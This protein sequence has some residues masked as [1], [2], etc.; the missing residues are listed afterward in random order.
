LAIPVQAADSIYINAYTDR[1]LNTGTVNV[2]TSN[3]TVY[4]NKGAWAKYIVDFSTMEAT[5]NRVELQYIKTAAVNG[6]NIV[7]I[8][9]DLGTNVPDNGRQIALIPTGN[10][11]NATSVKNSVEFNEISKNYLIGTKEV[12]VVFKG[13]AD[14]AQLQ[15]IR[16]YNSTETQNGNMRDVIIP[17]LSYTDMTP[18][19]PITDIEVNNSRASVFFKKSGWVKYGEVNFDLSPYPV[20]TLDIISGFSGTAQKP[21]LLFYIDGLPGENGAVKIGEFTPKVDSKE[22]APLTLETVN[23]TSSISGIHNLYVINGG[24]GLS[25]SYSM[26]R[27]YKK[28]SNE[29]TAILGAT[30]SVVTP[31]DI[32]A[33]DRYTSYYDYPGKPYDAN[34]IRATEIWPTSNSSSIKLHGNFDFGDGTIKYNKIAIDA[35]V[36]ENVANYTGKIEVWVDGLDT[37]IKLGEVLIDRVTDGNKIYQTFDT[38]VIGNVPYYTGAD[39][40]KKH[41]VFLRF[42]YAY[43]ANV[44]S[45]K[46][47]SESNNPTVI[48]SI[49]ED[50]SILNSTAN[51]PNTTDGFVIS[52]PNGCLND[53]SDSIYLKDDKNNNLLINVSDIDGKVHIKLNE[54]LH[55]NSKYTL[56][57][58]DSIINKLMKKTTLNDFDIELTQASIAITSSEIKANSGGSKINFSAQI[59]GQEQNLTAIVSVLDSNNKLMLCKVKS[60]LEW[61][62]IEF[63]L[64]IDGLIL[65]KNDKIKVLLIGSSYIPIADYVEYIVN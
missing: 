6:S 45:I 64:N 59:E 4:G 11:V 54:Y 14:F 29:K 38:D 53:L 12:F 40:D 42:S 31:N 34:Y 26:L 27:F 52:F 47:Y 49:L 1:V 5:P 39:N 2:N 28:T 8:V 62:N 57:M 33:C 41:K 58:P 15:A 65:N 22:Y 35:S 44:A 18:N 36:M 23:L 61:N 16:F 30:A 21:V 63:D 46:F 25:A 7:V 43:L 37:G 51:L 17:A 19:A 50:G 13:T 24:T 56:D 3:S 10:T 32:I 60:N 55:S 48:Q 9:S 20:D